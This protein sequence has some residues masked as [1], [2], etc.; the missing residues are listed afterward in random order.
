[1]SEQNGKILALD[2]GDKT[3]GVAV[4]DELGITA[5]GLFTIE[6]T[7]IKKDTAMVMDAITEN[8]CSRV[9]VGLPLRLDGTDSAQTQKT[10]EFTKKLENKLRSSG[11]ADISVEFYDERFTTKMAEHAMKEAGVRA[12][13]RKSLVDKIAAAVILQNY[14]N[15]RKSF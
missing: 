5:W 6:R 2:V 10:R 3:I 15:S 4:S 11:M 14:L 7:S 8:K 1:L 13:K 12:D 9:I